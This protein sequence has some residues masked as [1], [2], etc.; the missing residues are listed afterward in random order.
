MSAASDT[1]AQTALEAYDQAQREAAL[2][3]GEPIV[4]LAGPAVAG[5]RYGYAPRGS[6]LVWRERGLCV[7]A[8]QM[9]VSRGREAA[10]VL[11]RY[12]PKGDKAEGERRAFF[13]DRQTFNFALAKLSDLGGDGQ[14][15]QHDQRAARDSYRRMRFTAGLPISN[16]H[17]V[18]TDA[19]ARKYSA[20]TGVDRTSFAGWARA[21]G[22]QPV[23]AT[24]D[25]MVDLIAKLGGDINAQPFVKTYLNA[26]DS[27]ESAGLAA[28]GFA[29]LSAAGTA[30][31]Y[32]TRATTAAEAYL[33]IDRLRWERNALSGVLHTVS[34]STRPE[35]VAFDGRPAL[36]AELS[37][38]FSIEPNREIITINPE[39]GR[40][41]KLSLCDE[42]VLG[43]AD[44]IGR[45]GWFGGAGRGSGAR[46]IP[47]LSN[48]PG[49]RLLMYEAPYLAFGSMAG[50][51]RWTKPASQRSGGSGATRRDVPLAVT[52]AGA[53]SRPH[54]H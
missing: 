52:I 1:V 31:A 15:A 22:L 27:S 13:A 9:E 46:S 43:G 42:I 48:G 12:L 50:P 26:A 8:D 4:R 44:D 28:S 17:V 25:L 30:F 45:L 14:L 6:V 19:L 51:K 41:A 21:F 32:A 23:S 11:A 16:R 33:A 38:S 39:L 18:L 5:L 37:D 34:E 40:V 47:D 7:G 20:P 24:P 49:T 54:R 53:P 29:S 3:A 10:M 2:A 35:G 36:F